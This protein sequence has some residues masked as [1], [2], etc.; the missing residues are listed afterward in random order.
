SSGPD[1]EPGPARLTRALGTALAAGAL[2]VALAVVVGIVA[3][4]ALGVVER[5]GLLAAVTVDRWLDRLVALLAVVVVGVVIGVGVATADGPVARTRLLGSVLA[6][7][8]AGLVLAASPAWPGAAV[9]VGWSAG[10]ATTPARF[11][12]AAAPGLVV[13]LVGFAIESD[14]LSGRLVAGAVA[15]AVSALAMVALAAIGTPHPRDTPA[16]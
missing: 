6:G 11:A 16:P 2:G 10:L 15:A 5:S 7:L 12:I 1:S 14:S 8:G 9:A 3:T 4:A 13:G